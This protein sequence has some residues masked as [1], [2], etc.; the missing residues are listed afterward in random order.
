V[1]FHIRGFGCRQPAGLELF[2]GLRDSTLRT[3]E[4]PNTGSLQHA[5]RFGPAM[6][7]NQALGSEPEN[8]FR[9]LN[10]R[11]LGQIQILGIVESLKL[12]ALGVI[13]DKFGSSAKPGIYCRI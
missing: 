2:D 3:G 9:C 6:A 12:L 13:Q 1:S 4:Y 8:R 7:G 10:P 5:E 11:A